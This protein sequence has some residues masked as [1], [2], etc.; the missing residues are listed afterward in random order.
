QV[1]VSGQFLI[2]SEASLSGLTQRMGESSAGAGGDKPLRTAAGPIHEGTGTVEELS[3]TAVTLKHGPIASL[4]WGPM[5]MPF[6]LPSPDV[7]K[8]VKA[9]DSVRFRFRQADGDFVIESIEKTG[10]GR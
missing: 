10:G 5:T 1:A 6:S 7:A 3:A 2:D 8:G 4:Q 9:G